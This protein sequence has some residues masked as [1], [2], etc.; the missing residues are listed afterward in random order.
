MNRK[1]E[2]I[3]SLLASLLFTGCIGAP[4]EEADIE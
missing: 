2:I 3:A 1:R 4:G